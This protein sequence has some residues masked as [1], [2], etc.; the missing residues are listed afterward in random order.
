MNKLKRRLSVATL[1]L[2][3]SLAATGA[4]Q[5]ADFAPCIDAASKPALAGSLCAVERVAADPS[6][7]SG[8]PAAEF[9]LFVRKFPA[10]GQARGQVWLVAG[11]P[12]ES[13][14]SFYGL[15]PVLR[16]AFA[17]FDLL[18]PDHRGTGFST[19]CARTKNRRPRPAAP[20][21]LAPSGPAASGA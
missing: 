19:R 20:P 10:T 15:L 7:L 4:A 12:G 5:A 6:G 8:A 9:Q 1:S 2:G 3:L 16:K 21:W 17:G 11:G 18:V 13:G 14:A